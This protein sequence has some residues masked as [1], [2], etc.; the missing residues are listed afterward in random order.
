MPQAKKYLPANICIYCGENDIRLLTEEHIIPYSL[1]G[2]LKL[3]KSSCRKCASI[4]RG[5]TETIS[6]TM[7]GHVRIRLNAPTRNKNQRPKH[8]KLNLKSPNGST[9]EIKIP[10]ELW[11]RTYPVLHLKEATVLSKVQQSEFKVEILVDQRDIDFLYRYGYVSLHETIHITHAFEAKAFCRQLAQIGHA[12][13]AAEIGLD[14]FQPWLVPLIMDQSKE[15]GNELLFI[16]NASPHEALSSKIALD[17][18]KSH[19]VSFIVCRFTMPDL[20]WRFPTYQIVCGT[21][22]D[23]R[24]DGLSMQIA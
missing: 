13:A 19:G 23:D 16:G 3:P 14:A 15:M 20:G 18:V 9:R 12:F 17:V 5:I 7:Y 4:T 10:A 6:R 11:P 2:F 24:F 22:A 8:L 21:V 1:G